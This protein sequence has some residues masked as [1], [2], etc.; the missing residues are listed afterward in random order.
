MQNLINDI[1]HSFKVGDKLS[2]KVLV[3]QLEAN[4]VVIFQNILLKFSEAGRSQSSTFSFW[5]TFINEVETLLR[6]LR[7]E[8]DC[9][10]ELHLNAVCEVIPWFR[11]ADR[12]NYVKYLPLYVHDIKSLREEHQSPTNICWREVFLSVGLHTNSIQL[13]VIKHWNRQLIVKVK[14]KEV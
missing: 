8:H 14:V 3:E 13:S 12:T 1:Q 11:A 5:D 7:A 2:A 4:Q 10:F 6:L 9:L